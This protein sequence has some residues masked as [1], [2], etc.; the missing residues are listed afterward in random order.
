MN[1]IC[2]PQTFRCGKCN[3]AYQAR[4]DAEKCCKQDIP[5]KIIAVDFDGTLCD[6]NFP[7]CGP[8]IQSVI[9]AL[10]A[11]QAAGAKV[12]LWTCRRDEA[13]RKAVEWCEQHGIHLDAVNENLPE[14]IALYG[15]DTRKISADEY[16]DDLARRMP[17]RV[18]YIGRRRGKDFDYCFCYDCLARWEPDKKPKLCP[19][20]GARIEREE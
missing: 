3:R 4:S 6:S 19:G 1:V 14:R 9:D 11:E 17:E 15:N 18:C 20:C 8:P 2:E 12:I 7:E 16:W 10:K 13:L 5:A